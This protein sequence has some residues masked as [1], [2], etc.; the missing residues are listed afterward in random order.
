MSTWVFG[1]GSLVAPESAG[2]T[3]ER[4]IEVVPA[5]L[6][7]WRRRWSLLRDNHHSEKTFALA[8]GSL[9]DFIL[10]LNAEAEGEDPAGPVNGGLI[11][12]FDGELD[13]LDKR[14]IRYDRVDVSEQ[15][16]LR[17][18]ELEGRVFTYTAKRPQHF[19]P[20]PPPN[21]VIVAAY[22]A[23]VEYGFEE[24]GDG[25]LDRFKATTGPPPVE[26]VEAS[27]VKDEI[28]PGNPRRW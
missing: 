8:D 27:L 15:I 17:D 9:P 26:V 6:H 2:H 7:G 25:E 23:I 5:D 21:S 18:G 22:L 16:S 10:G 14:E 13:R 12:L 3:L 20:E 4:P 24:L 28:P 11:E 1:Y 19:A